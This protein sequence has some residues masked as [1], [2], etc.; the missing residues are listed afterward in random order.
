MS[1]LTQIPQ[2]FSEA[3]IVVCLFFQQQVPFPVFITFI[4]GLCCLKQLVDGRS[5]AHPSAHAR[6]PSP[7]HL[8]IRGRSGGRGGHTNSSWVW[9]E[10]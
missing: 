5:A 9:K 1:G 6:L 7:A 10:R 2:N 3:W 4:P 8:G